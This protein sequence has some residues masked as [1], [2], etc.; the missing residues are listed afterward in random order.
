MNIPTYE[1]YILHMPINQ[2]FKCQE[3]E[4]IDQAQ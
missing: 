4:F 2:L 3:E 1:L